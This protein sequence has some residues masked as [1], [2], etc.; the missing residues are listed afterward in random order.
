MVG[1]SPLDLLSRRG[2]GRSRGHA[3][4]SEMMAMSG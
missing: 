2:E 1:I 3:Y 4:T